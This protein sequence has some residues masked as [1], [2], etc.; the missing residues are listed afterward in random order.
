MEYITLNTGTKIPIL[1]LG[2]YQ[3][4]PADTAKA[5]ETAIKIGYRSFDT[6]QY[7]NNELEVG[8][9]IKASGIDRK[10]VFITTKADTDGY[11]ETMRGIDESMEKLQVDYLDMMLLHWPK[12]QAVE[13]YHALEDAYEAGKIKA[14]GLSNFNIKETNDL[15]DKTTIMPA[16]DQIETNLYLQQD[17]MHKFLTDLG[18]V[19]E[20]WSPLAQGSINLNNDLVLKMIG[21]KYSKSGIQVLLRFL[22]Q[23]KIMTIPRSINPKHMEQNF[24]IFDFELTSEEMTAIK[25]LDKHRSHN[26]WPQWMAVDA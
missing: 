12:P 14:I 25:N 23:S 8:N 6:A 7:Y 18:I 11:D 24:D 13:S 1:G 21:E 26:G 16:V 4:A 20:S 3:I 15:I 10:E 5:V 2:T 19:H 9:G 22:T 17:K